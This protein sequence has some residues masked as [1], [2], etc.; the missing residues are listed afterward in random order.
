MCGR[1]VSRIIPDGYMRHRQSPCS[2][3]ANPRC[4]LAAATSAGPL[5]AKGGTLQAV[6]CAAMLIVAQMLPCRPNRCTPGQVSDTSSIH[7]NVG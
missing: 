3:A 6:S 7:S 2:V 5:G 4:D 1:V